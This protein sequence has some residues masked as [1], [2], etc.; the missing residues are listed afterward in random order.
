MPDRWRL[1]DL[2]ILLAFYEGAAV[3]CLFQ[4]RGGGTRV[5]AP[6]AARHYEL[7]YY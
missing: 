2:A 3:S 5:A 7:I 4:E 1:A 6:L